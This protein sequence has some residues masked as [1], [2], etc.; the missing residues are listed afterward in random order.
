M[1]FRAIIEYIEEMAA[2]TI[3][4]ASAI[5]QIALQISIIATSLERAN[6]AASK[7][8]QVRA[9]AP[10]AEFIDSIVPMEEQAQLAVERLQATFKEQRGQLSRHLE[11]AQ[12]HIRSASIISST[13]KVEASD[14]EDYQQHLLVIAANIDTAASTIKQHLHAASKLL[15]LIDQR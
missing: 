15:Q 13:S 8:R 11:D 6:H 10:D 14:T 9:M 5:N 3:E 1:G 12:K 4:Q 2:N 7:F